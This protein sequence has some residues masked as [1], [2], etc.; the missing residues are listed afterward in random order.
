MRIS[1]IFLALLF[2]GHEASSQ[3]DSLQRE[4]NQQVWKPFI[5]AF[6]SMDT[7]RFMAVHSK[8]MSRVIQ[9]GNTM[10]GY[11]KHYEETRRENDRSK[12]SKQKR[13]IELRFIQ[14]IAA[15]SKAFEVGYYK[16]TS[17][18]PDG[19]ARTGYGK[20]HVLLHKENGT[21]KILMDAD[22]SAKTDEALFLQGKSI[23]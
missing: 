23:E 14:R 17:Y 20:F 4:I 8:Q 7:E 1:A 2:W 5:E 9:D 3:S 10:Y 11:E 22:A 18:L 15:S 6:N 16:S 12:Q 21:W 19:R 13:S